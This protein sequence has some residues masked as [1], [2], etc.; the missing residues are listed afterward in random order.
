MA[1]H[2]AGT[3]RIGDGRGGAGGMSGDRRPAALRAAQQLAGQRQPRQGARLLWPIKQKYG[4][5]ISWADLLILAG[6]VALESMGFPETFGF[7]GGRAD[8]WEPSGHLLGP[9]GQAGWRRALQ[10][11]PR[12]RR[13]ARRRADGPDLR[14]P[15][16]RTATPIRSPRRATSARPSPAWRWTTRRRWRPIAGGHTFGKAHGAGDA[17]RWSAPEPG[18]GDRAAG[19]RLEEQLRHRARARH[20]HQRPR[21]DLDHDADAMEQRLLQ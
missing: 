11:R 8:V 10:R 12:A 6:N 7:G 14:Q 17:R 3:Y 19:L 4:R 18:R 15:G 9:R 21:G 2:S 13:S 16:G 5:K 1:W 20:D